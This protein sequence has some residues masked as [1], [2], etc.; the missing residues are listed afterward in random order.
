MEI[1]RCV[2]DNTCVNRALHGAEVVCVVNPAVGREEQWGK[3]TL[4]QTTSPKRVVVVGAG[5]AGLRFAAT[6]AQ[7]GHRV[8]VH[9]RETEPGG[10]LREI[11]WLPTRESW[12]YAAA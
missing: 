3:G 9:E 10:H 5:P 12:R 2:G 8:S 6:V 11:A 4:V 1:A 7:R